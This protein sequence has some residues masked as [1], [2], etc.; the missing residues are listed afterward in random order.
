MHLPSHK[1][2]LRPKLATVLQHSSGSSTPKATEPPAPAKTHNSLNIKDRRNIKLGVVALRTVS[3]WTAKAA[4]TLEKLEGQ[5]ASKHC[6]ERQARLIADNSGNNY[7]KGAQDPGVWRETV[8]YPVPAPAGDAREIEVHE[9]PKVYRV[10]AP[11]SKEESRVT[12]S[13]IAVPLIET[14]HA[15]VLTPVA[16]YYNES[17]D[18]EDEGE[19][20]KKISLVNPTDVDADEDIDED[21]SDVSSDDKKEDDS[22]EDEESHKDSDDDLDSEEH[23]SSDDAEDSEEEE[24][25]LKHPIIAV[26]KK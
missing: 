25:D 2:Q 14:Q 12:A 15:R 17:S 24:V 13:A 11:F 3:K 7:G 6:Q 5:E 26:A 21:S 8:V 23:D 1:L 16:E 20:S 10:S 9:E 19:Q 18:D 22:D 4:L